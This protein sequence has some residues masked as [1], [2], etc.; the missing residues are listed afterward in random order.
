MESVARELIENLGGLSNISKIEDCITR[1]R[2]SVK[3]LDKINTQKI[4]ALE[5]VMH[6]FI[7]DTV[8]IV[9]GPGKSRKIAKIMRDYDSI[10]IK[11]E[12][13]DL[14][15]RKKLNKE[16]NKNFRKRNFFEFVLEKFR[17]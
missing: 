13:N 11:E 7:S 10:E 4:K 9:L 12:G 8:H 14:K 6:I 17:K 2:F 5:E 15:E 16:E 1:I 3:S